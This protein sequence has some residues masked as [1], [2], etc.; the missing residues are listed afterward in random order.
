M[1]DAELFAYKCPYTDKP[2]YSWECESCEVEQEEREWC[3][4]ME[5][6]DSDAVDS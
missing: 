4:Q 1:T 3:E 2:C 5:G 6:S